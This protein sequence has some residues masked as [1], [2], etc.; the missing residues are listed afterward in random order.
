MIA[1]NIKTELNQ[2]SQG[3]ALWEQ[4]KL[5][6]KKLRVMNLIKYGVVLRIKKSML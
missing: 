3:L 4:T 5:T 6:N 2:K 1:T